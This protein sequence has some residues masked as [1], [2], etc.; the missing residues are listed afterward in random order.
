MSVIMANDSEDTNKCIDYI[1]N[2]AL[3]AD[4][5]ECVSNFTECEE[6]CINTEGSFYCSCYNPGY[7]LD[8]TGLNCTDINECTEVDNGGCKHL[9]ENTLGGYNCS[10]LTGYELGNDSHSCQD[11]NECTEKSNGGCNQ[12]CINTVG[13]YYCSCRQEFKLMDDLHGCAIDECIL[14]IDEC[15]QVCIDTQESYYCGC[16]SGYELDSDQFNCTDIDECGLEVTSCTQGCDNLIGSFSCYCHSGYYPALDRNSCLKIPSLQVLPLTPPD[17]GLKGI[18]DGILRT[19]DDYCADMRRFFIALKTYGYTNNN[20]TLNGHEFSTTMNISKNLSAFDFLGGMFGKRHSVVLPISTRVEFIKYNC[21]QHAF[22]LKTLAGGKLSVFPNFLEL[23][24]VSVHITTTVN[25]EGEFSKISLIEMQGLWSIGKFTSTVFLDTTQPGQWPIRAEFPSSKFDFNDLLETTHIELNSLLPLDLSFKLN[26]MRGTLFSEGGDL[27]ILIQL[28]GRLSFGD[29]IDVQ[30]CVVMFQNIQLTSPPQVLI[31][32]DCCSTHASLNFQLTDVVQELLGVNIGNVAFFGDLIMSNVQVFI[33]S[34]ASK[35]PNS[36]LNYYCPNMSQWDVPSITALKGI[37]FVFK[38]PNVLP[39]DIAL[40]TT[41]NTDG[42]ALHFIP[43][44]DSGTLRVRDLLAVLFT[45]FIPPTFSGAIS[46]LDILDLNIKHFE[47]NLDQK[48]LSIKVKYPR[49]LHV[50]RGCIVIQNIFVEAN[51]SLHEMNLQISAKGQFSIGH[52]T[53]H[54]QIDVD[55]AK[56][57]LQLTAKSPK[58]CLVHIV[59]AFKVHIP[60]FLRRTFHLNTLCLTDV[61]FKVNSTSN[62]LC[63]AGM[64]TLW[65]RSFHLYLCADGNNGNVLVGLTL[66]NFALSE[67]LSNFIGGIAKRIPFL[68]HVLDINILYT[69]VPLDSIPALIAYIPGID[70]VDESFE[71]GLTFTGTAGW[72]KSCD[73]DILC[74][75]LQFFLGNGTTSLKLP[76]Y[77]HYQLGDFSPGPFHVQFNLPEMSIGPIRIPKPVLQVELPPLGSPVP[78]SIPS[79]ALSAKVDFA[80]LP[81]TV[82]VKYRALPPSVTLGLATKACLYVVPSFIQVCNLL[83]SV[84]L[85]PSPMPISGFAFGANVKIGFPRCNR[86][87]FDAIFSYDAGDATQNYIY[88]HTN[89]PLTVSSIPAIICINI[90]LPPVLRDTG[91]P[92]GF[93]LSYSAVGQYIKHLNI[94]IPQGLYFKGLLNIFRF[95]LDTEIK[96][97]NS[98]VTE[99]YLKCRLPA[100][101]LAN[102]ALIMSESSS[103]RDKGPFLEAMIGRRV[104]VK[105]LLYVSVLGISVEATLLIKGQELSLS[106]SGSILGLFHANVKIYGTYQPSIHSIAWNVEVHLKNDFFNFVIGKVKEAIS[107]I[108]QAAKVVTAPLKATIAVA[109]GVF[110]VAASGLHSAREGVRRFRDQVGGAVREVG[111]IRNKINSVCH[112]RSCGTGKLFHICPLTLLAWVIYHVHLIIA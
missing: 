45:N 110:D 79:F 18:I 108:D 77:I 73:W 27:S 38:V 37:T 2:E 98:P 68:N 64:V 41:V 82:S 23:T 9:C 88:V 102:G 46:D 83:L 43:M 62:N 84:T 52:V 105:A 63:F 21:N 80:G 28:E 53:I 10:C 70:I 3:C 109:Q 81:F 103:V 12:T 78:P 42:I 14:G 20:I 56:N 19:S 48:Q 90:P 97:I 111:R 76:L 85:T 107:K 26:N 67:L 54:A 7:R 35:I 91:F 71:A 8:E 11:I 22:T 101:N 50:Y 75:I 92:K 61:V 57:S 69:K 94:K 30:G 100:L 87:V 34:V 49:K 60:S 5:N 15:S 86:L 31:L 66:N 51:T 93:T 47:Y 44:I 24:S 112:I 6:V 74:H 39:I 58:L 1:A 59:K 96:Y 104:S 16:S 89:S 13:S 95:T 36:F 4:T 33:P 72:P 32:S 99:F 17:P 40:T 65:S 25:H 29:L 55:T 106:I